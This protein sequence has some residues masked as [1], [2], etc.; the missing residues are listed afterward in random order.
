[1]VITLI[2]I[3][4]IDTYLII[5]KSHIN[6]RSDIVPINDNYNTY[7]IPKQEYK[8]PI[9]FIT[10]II[11]VYLKLFVIFHSSVGR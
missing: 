4:N 11:I 1:M 3:D 8:L 7:C 2:T 5:F 9:K 6:N 10:Y